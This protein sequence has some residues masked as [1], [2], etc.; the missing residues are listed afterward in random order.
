MITLCLLLVP[1]ETFA[2]QLWLDPARIPTHVGELVRVTVYLNSESEEINAVEGTLVVPK[3]LLVV[4]QISISN[5]IVN[6]WLERPHEGAGEAI[7]FSGIIPG[8]LASERGLLFSLVL[9]AK[10]EGA[11]TFHITQGKVFLNDGAGTPT[12][13][14]TNQGLIQIGR[15]AVTVSGA[16]QALAEELRFPDD[17]EP[18]ETFAPAVGQDPAILDGQYFVVFAGTDKKSGIAYYEVQESSKKRAT[19]GAWKRAESPLILSDQKLQSFIFIKA[20]DTVG[21]ER[22]IT[23]PPRNPQAFFQRPLF[24]GILILIVLVIFYDREKRKV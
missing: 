9:E 20:V 6:F 1:V 8:G 23:L 12:T 24:W 4:K 19:E 16:S 21:N 2:A 15:R 17:T 11:A 10:Q 14:R 22:I 3:N 7:A 13:A 18:P 5:S